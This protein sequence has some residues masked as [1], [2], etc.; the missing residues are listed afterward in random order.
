MEP[1]QRTE[2]GN[3]LTDEAPL[4]RGVLEQGMAGERGAGSP[5]AMHGTPHPQGQSSVE[6]APT[7]WRKVRRTLPD[8]HTALEQIEHAAWPR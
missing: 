3:R 6:E 8:I 1:R 7:S 2:M 4:M 5:P